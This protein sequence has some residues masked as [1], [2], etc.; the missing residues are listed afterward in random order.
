MRVRYVVTMVI[1]LVLCFHIALVPA[2]APLLAQPAVSSEFQTVIL[3]A[4]LGLIAHYPF[5]VDFSDQSGNGNDAT[6]YGAALVPVGSGQALSLDGVNDYVYVPVDINPEVM[7]QLTIALWAQATALTGTLI[8]HDNGGYDRCL[9]IDYRGGGLGWSA[10]SGSGGVLG[11]SPVILGEWVFLAVI[12]DQDAGTVRF[13]VNDE[14]YEEDGTLDSGLDYLHIGASPSF[15]S[16][17]PGYIDEVR[18]YNQALSQNAISDLRASMPAT[19][20][21]GTSLAST[22]RRAATGC[23]TRRT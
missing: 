23:S 4:E 16:H 15:G 11:Y 2:R 8:S 9:D 12:Y 7:P 5:D 21:S 22:P 19:A 14:V 3:T 20:A 18:I 17:F 6:N 1:A 10:F 13:H